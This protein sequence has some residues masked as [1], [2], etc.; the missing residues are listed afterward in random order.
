MFFHAELTEELL[1]EPKDFGPALRS[2]LKERLKENVE[3]RV[4]GDAGYVVY[5]TEVEDAMIGHGR[6]D[7]VTGKA[8]YN[9]TFES[10]VFRLFRNEVVEAVVSFVHE[11]GFH[12]NVGPVSVFVSRHRMP[13]EY[14][15]G[16][17]M[18]ENCWFHP[19][20]SQV[21]RGKA[22]IVLKI[23]STRVEAKEISAVGTM[24]PEFCKVVQE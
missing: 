11:N 2:K 14:Q 10:I 16:F 5:V 13:E 21:V 9:V 7:D 18:T 12:A 22:R 15:D 6:L 8:I 23:E 24:L 4:V 19:D 17:D 3:G 20:P 1:L